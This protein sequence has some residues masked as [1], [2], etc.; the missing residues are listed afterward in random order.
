M[1]ENGKVVV[2]GCMGAEPEKITAK[3]PNVFAVTGP[4]Q[5]ET[6]VRLC[7]VHRRQRMI[8]LST[9]CPPKASS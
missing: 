6:V 2:T 3:F 9:L 4:Q 5:Y 8:P 7:I 1:A